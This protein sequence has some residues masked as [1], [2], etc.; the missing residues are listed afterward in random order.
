[1]RQVPDNQE[2]FVDADGFASLT[3]DIMERVSHLSTDSEALEYHFADI[4]GADDSKEV[5]SVVENLKL[6]S[7]P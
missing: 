1:M 2:V 7:F 4:V 6:P 5:T 3:F